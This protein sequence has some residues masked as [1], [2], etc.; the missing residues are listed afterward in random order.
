MTR[1]FLSVIIASKGRPDMLQGTVECLMK[2][3]MMPQEIIVAVTGE[4]DYLPA[5]LAT[6]QLRLITSPAGSAVQRNR[7]IA[8][9]HPDSTVTAFLDDDVE[10]EDAYLAK[11]C[12]FMEAHPDVAG[13]SGAPILDK[14]RW[15][16]MER[17]EARQI[18]H[19]TVLDASPPHESRELYGCN[20]TLRTAAVRQEQ[21]DER[22]ILYAYLEDRDYAAHIA[23]HG[24]I[25][26]YTA[27]K[28][29]HFGSRSGRVSEKLMGYT[30]MMNSTYLLR[31][32]VLTPKEYGR[33][34]LGTLGA[35]LLRTLGIKHNGEA[36]I[37][38]RATRRLRLQGNVLAIK[39][40]ML[41][42]I[43]PERVALLK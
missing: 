15:G 25:V 14:P 1:P 9:L 38:D 10:M 39:D 31:K 16:Q 6:P 33:L 40:I 37:L 8:E 18:L 32:G 2:Q 3:T 23:R 17:E 24:R 13:F 12:A 29:I 43:Q 7:A 4:E 19:N 5:L 21:F 26:G 35:N 27:A 36:D 28:L 11:V 34:G 41:Y 30:Q 22:L 20:M 42:G